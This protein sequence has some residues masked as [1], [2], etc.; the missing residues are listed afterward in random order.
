LQAAEKPFLRRFASGHGFSR[1]AKPV[2]LVLASE[3]SPLAFFGCEFFTGRLSLAVG[4]CFSFG[5]YS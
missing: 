2:V 5:K 3:L 1:A 4:F